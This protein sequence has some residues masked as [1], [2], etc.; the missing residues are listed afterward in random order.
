MFYFIVGSQIIESCT[1]LVI[2][3]HVS[4]TKSIKIKLNKQSK[5]WSLFCQMFM[6]MAEQERR[7]DIGEVFLKERDLG[8]V[9]KTGED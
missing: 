6:Q 7:E 2:Q 3:A 1:V 4:H 5:M 9:L 8:C